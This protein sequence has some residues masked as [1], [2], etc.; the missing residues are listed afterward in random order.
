VCAALALTTGNIELYRLGFLASFASKLADTTSS[1]V[2]KAYGKT[3][4]LITSL[5][6][7]PRGTEGAVSLEGTLAGVFAAAGVAAVAAVL[8]QIENVNGIIAVV[9]ASLIANVF[10]SIVGASVQGKVDWLTNDVVN[11]LQIS[12]AAMIAIALKLYFQ[13]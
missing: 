6:L 10:E 11:G 8:G 7:V 4:Y 5:K 2:G 9:V 12:V 13:F 3:T 1:E